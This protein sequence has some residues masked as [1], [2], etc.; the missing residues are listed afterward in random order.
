MQRE[1]LSSPESF[2][3]FKNC[4]YNVQL[5]HLEGLEGDSVLIENDENSIKKWECVLTLD[6]E[7]GIKM[8]LT[9]DDYNCF[10]HNE[11]PQV[12][13]YERVMLQEPDK[14][15]VFFLHKARFLLSSV[16]AKKCWIV[17]LTL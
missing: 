14:N 2:N 10:S 8:S 1:N 12:C 3:F 9:K 4:S 13:I 11:E 16:G 7:R 15:N 17:P 6:T 5:V